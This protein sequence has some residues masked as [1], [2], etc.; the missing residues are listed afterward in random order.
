MKAALVVFAVVRDTR[1]NLEAILRSIAA[2]SAAG[3]DLVLFP[4]AALTGLVNE[5]HPEWDR[6]LGRPIPGPETDRLA[7]A[8]RRRGIFVGTGLF[9]IAGRRLY[10][11]AVLLAPDGELIL[12]YRRNNPG[13]RDPD[14]DPAVYGEG[15]E[16]PVLAT[17]HGRLAFLI[18]GDLFDDR[19]LARL[20]RSWPDVVLFP[21]ARAF[22]EGG[23]E[24]E[25]WHREEAP[26]YAERVEG[27]GATFLM[28]NQLG[29]EYF[30]G[31]MAVAPDG[32]I[33]ASLPPREPGML[34]V[35]V[36]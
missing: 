2:A 8:A 13:W 1:R 7:E 12:H 28:V 21:F 22:E 16:V 10:D 15:D 32:T 24:R 27:L 11:S 34:L 18:C 3:A 36:G 26:A 33:V 14:A 23:D 6:T 20:H 9:E 5:D 35:E 29:G 30:G 19:V 31:A 17:E 4:E 25:R